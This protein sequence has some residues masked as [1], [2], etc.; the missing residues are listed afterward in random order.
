MQARHDYK[1]TLKHFQT[2]FSVHKI[3]V[4]DFCLQLGNRAHL[5][6][7]EFKDM[8]WLPINERVNQRICVHILFNN[9]SP[10]SM[11]DI[12][13]PNKLTKHTRN[14]QHNFKVPFQRTNMGQNAISYTGPYLWNS[15]S[16]DI[17]LAKTRNEFKHKIKSTHWF[18]HTTHIREH[19]GT[20]HIDLFLSPC[21]IYRGGLRVREIEIIFYLYCPNWLFFF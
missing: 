3:K 2:K 12:F 5:D 17:K 1:T 18:R 11:S 16:I 19:Y 6:K 14:S 20:R 13:T 4:S 15:L 8:N 7:K 10:S 9:S 21:H